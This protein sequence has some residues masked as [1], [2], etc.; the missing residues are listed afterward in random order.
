MK[1]VKVKYRKLGKEQAVGIAYPNHNL[2]ELDERLKGKALFS[3]LLHEA[4]HHALPTITEE[5]TLRLER[6]I[7]AIM[8]RERKR[9][10]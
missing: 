7:T 5:E 2:I 6:E 9:W 10:N 4:I 8:W 1:K 3:T